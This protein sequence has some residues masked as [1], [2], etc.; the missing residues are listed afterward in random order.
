MWFNSPHDWLSAKIAN[1]WTDKQVINAFMSLL[2]MIDNDTIQDVFESE[3]DADGYFDHRDK[4]PWRHLRRVV[5]ATK[6]K[7]RMY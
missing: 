3:M 5:E 7:G 1:G 6:A 4:D 2:P